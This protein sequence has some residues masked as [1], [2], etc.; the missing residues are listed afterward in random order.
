MQLKQT[1]GGGGWGRKEEPRRAPAPSCP[2][3]WGCSPAGQKPLCGCR[4][5]WGSQASH[6][7]AAPRGRLRRRTGT[8]SLQAA[9]PPASCLVPGVGASGSSPPRSPDPPPYRAGQGP[10]ALLS[11]R[12]LLRGGFCHWPLALAPVKGHRAG[13]QWGSGTD[14]CPRGVG[15]L[16]L[17]P[18]GSSVP[19]RFRAGADA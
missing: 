5:G 1:R 19:G 9:W 16:W 3:P 15:E 10:C 12:C 6:P 18:W 8:S 14:P 4:P 7:S 2:P 13:V 17:P 11:P